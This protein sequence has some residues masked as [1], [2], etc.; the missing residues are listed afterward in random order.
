[1]AA[2]A[3]KR[4]GPTIGYV[5]FVHSPTMKLVKIGYTTGDP[6]ARLG[7]MQTDSA[8]ILRLI[9]VVRCENPAVKEQWFHQEYSEYRVHGEWFKDVV[10]V[11]LESVI[12]EYLQ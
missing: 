9:G 11:P 1:M 6:L 2:A 10:L 12:T 4:R 8:D 5:Y 7:L 3:A